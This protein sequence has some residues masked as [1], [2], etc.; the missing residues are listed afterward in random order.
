MKILI[1]NA[2]SSSLKYS[3]FG[4]QSTCLLCHGLIERIGGDA[5]HEYAA[6]DGV[7]Q[8]LA[9][10]A[11]DHQQAL[12][13]VF[14]LLA[15]LE[16]LTDIK[17]LAGV[18]HRVVHGGERFNRPT[19]ITE[20]VLQQID[21]ACPLAPLHNP[22]NLLGIREAMRQLPGIAQVAVFDT[23]YHQTLPDYAYRYALPGELYRDH[24]VR[25]YGFHGVSHFYVA[26]QA[27][28]FLGKPLTECNF[29]TLH[30]G[31]GASVAAIAGGK[32]V[33]TSMGLTPLEGLVMGSRSGD[34]DPAIPFYLHR[35]LGL[36]YPAIE[37]LL[38]KNSGCKGLCGDNDLRNIHAR[39]NVGDADAC[40][41][42][43]IYAYRIKKYIGAYFAVL[44]HVDG[45]VF[46]GG[47]G[48][49]DA[50]VRAQSCAGL[51]A[52]GIGIDAKTNAKPARPIGQIS[53][54]GAPTAVL[55]VATDEELEIALQ[56][57][58]CLE[59]LDQ[60]GV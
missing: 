52:L 51:S 15:R 57:Q 49:N 34:L 12:S 29:I 50:W 1:L 7:K 38:N 6:P 60:A 45:I 43:E 4:L 36:D 32:S 20:S 46:T 56:T 35:A 44:N 58:A 48:E 55:V 18:G 21:A 10:A 53:P 17:S 23:A 37:E 24:A 2:G 54:P 5:S 13:V 25:R 11:A 28:A 47:V 59:A 27:A 41:T 3:L 19:L 22:A 30:L 9:I 42:L 40:L 39:A 16:L 33:D 14:Q 31:N 8:T 26:K